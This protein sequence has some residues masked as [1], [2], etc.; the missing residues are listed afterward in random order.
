MKWKLILKTYFDKYNIVEIR[1]VW[2]FPTGFN[3]PDDWLSDIRKKSL[4]ESTQADID[5]ININLQQLAKDTYFIL[6]NK[7]I[8]RYLA[9][10]RIIYIYIYIYI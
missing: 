6:D 7:M 4:I 10:M 1:N 5:A 3:P 2:T 8:C 9:G